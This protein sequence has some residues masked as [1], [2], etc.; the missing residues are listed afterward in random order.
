MTSTHHP[1]VFSDTTNKNGLIQECEFWTNL[2]D[3][4]ISGDTTLLAQFTARINAGFDRISPILYKYLGFDDPNHNDEPAGTFDIVSG[5]YDYTI[6][7]DDNT[8]DILDI[9]GV[10]IFPSATAT[11]YVDLE[12]ITGDNINA[13]EVMSPNS[14]DVGVPSKYLKKGNTIFLTPQPNY[15]ATN[16]IKIY[17]SREIA[18]FDSSGYDTRE[19][20]IPRPFQGLLPLYA[21]YDWLIVN[22]PD[23]K[24]AI[25]RIEEQISKREKQLDNLINS[26]YPKRSIMTMSKINYI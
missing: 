17:F 18:Y 21:S 12:E 8:L 10:R 23:N 5:Q 1:L 24:M 9:T 19:A 14:D 3:G 4:T 11:Q 6:A 22:K 7:Q 13:M 2:G 20:G 25:T 16:G 15:N 26:R